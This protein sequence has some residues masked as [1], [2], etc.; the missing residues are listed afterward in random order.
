[1]EFMGKIPDNIRDKGTIA[2]PV[3]FNFYC[4]KISPWFVIQGELKAFL[5]Y[6]HLIQRSMMQ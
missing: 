1:M 3:L 5:L 6:L 4:F 2:T